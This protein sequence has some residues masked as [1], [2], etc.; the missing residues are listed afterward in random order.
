MLNRHFLMGI[1]LPESGQPSE[2]PIR[3]AGLVD[4]ANREGKRV[5][6]EYNHMASYLIKIKL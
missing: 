5:D 6:V 1:L 3:T 2:R 4:S